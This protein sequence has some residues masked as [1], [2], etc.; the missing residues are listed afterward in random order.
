VIE[1]STFD[2][3]VMTSGHFAA[4]RSGG[5]VMAPETEEIR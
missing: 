4:P 3:E 1:L 5:T 2:D